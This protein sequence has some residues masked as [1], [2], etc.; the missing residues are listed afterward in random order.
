MT[1]IAFTVPGQPQGKGRA[2]VGRVNGHARMFT[3][4]KTAAYEGLI[5]FAARHAMNGHDLLEGPCMVSMDIVCQIPT[6]WSAKK[7]RQAV[8]GA[9][10]PITK[11]DVDN[12]EKAVFDGCNGVVWKDDVQVV[13]VRKSKRYGLQPGVTV[14]IGYATPGLTMAQ[15]QEIVEA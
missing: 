14:V 7:Q 15:Q 6:S 5:A 8:S 2:R 13:D 1:C 12:V 10:R 4:A 11:P 3:P 9:I